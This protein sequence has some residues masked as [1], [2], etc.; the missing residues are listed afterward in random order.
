MEKQIVTEYFNFNN[1]VIQANLQDIS[2]EESL[3]KPLAEGNCVNWIFGHLLLTRNHLHELL[4]LDPAL[5]QRYQNLYDSGI[6]KQVPKDQALAIEQLMNNYQQS[7]QMVMST[8]NESHDEKD[9]DF[10]KTLS[11]LAFHEAYHAGQLG[12][13]RKG[14]GKEGKIG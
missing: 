11:G 8:L 1:Y 6:S 13:L 14:L 2:H 9:Q 4:K 10:W 3:Q 12:L 5:D 7:Q